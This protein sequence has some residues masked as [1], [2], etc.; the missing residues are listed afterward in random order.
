[1]KK[2]RQS[3]LNYTNKQHTEPLFPPFL[4]VELLFEQGLEPGGGLAYGRQPPVQRVHLDRQSGSQDMVPAA[5]RWRERRLP[6]QSEAEGSQFGDIRR[7]FFSNRV[8]DN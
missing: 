1:M 8:I 7:N 3:C 5:S 2:E 4:N 6:T